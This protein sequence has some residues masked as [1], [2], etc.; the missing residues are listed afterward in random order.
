[1]TRPGARVAAFVALLVA[2]FA[3]AAL[4]GGALDPEGGEHGGAGSMT[5]HGGDDGSA[6]TG[7][8][9][10]ASIAAR[11]SPASPSTSASASSAQGHASGHDHDASGAG[12]PAAGATPAG[13]GS[14]DG[15]YRLVARATRFAAGRPAPLTFRVLDADGTTVRRFEIEQARRMHVIVVRR[16]LRRYQH[17]HPTQA[18]DGG[19]T[20]SLRLP[21]AGVYRVFADFRIDGARHTLGMDLFVPGD[22]K[23]LDLPAPATKA[24]VDGYEVTLHERPGEAGF[25]VRRGGKLVTDLQPYLGARGHLVALRE[26]DL[27]YQHVHPGPGQPPEIAFHLGDS[28]PGTYRLFLQFRHDDRVHTAAFTRVVE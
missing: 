9:A 14:S 19:W 16:D 2:V 22:F 28:E 21:D 1:M 27:A 25:F 4:A 5:A 3:A 8:G 12:A 23:P 18:R 17:L 6:V 26:G 7:G 24:A 10:H 20:T 15:A 11:R 13:L